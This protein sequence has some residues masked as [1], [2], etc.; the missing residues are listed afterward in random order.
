VC[1]SDLFLISTLCY[2]RGETRP[3]PRWQ[4]AVS[5]I[6]AISVT[7][8]MG[9]I[10][11]LGVLLTGQ[12]LTTGLQ[13]LEFG[14]LGGGLFT[15]VAAAFGG[16]QAF[17]AGVQLSTRDFVNLL[18]SFLVIFGHWHGFCHAYWY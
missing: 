3:M 5:N 16:R 11:G 6:S 13:G 2:R 10:A 4:A 9:V 17:Q 8:A 7:I 1:S 18:V 12:V 14:Q 15:G